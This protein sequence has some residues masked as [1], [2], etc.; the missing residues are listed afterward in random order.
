MEMAR[1]VAPIYAH[2]LRLADR[3]KGEQ[4]K[5]VYNFKAGT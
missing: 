1:R 2:K 5:P 3:P 4:I